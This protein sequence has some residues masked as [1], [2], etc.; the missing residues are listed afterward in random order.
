MFIFRSVFERLPNDI[1]YEVFDYLQIIHIY[2]A[3]LDLNDRFQNLLIHSNLPMKVNISTMSKSTFKRYHV[4]VIIP[5]RYRIAYLRLFN[6]FTVEMIFYPP[7]IIEEF[8]QL[9]KLVLEQI[10]AKYIRNIL[11]HAGALEKLHS[12]VISLIEP[13]EDLRRLWTPIFLLR[14]LKYC[15]VTYDPMNQQIS[16]FYL[17]QHNESS[18]EHLVLNTSITFNSLDKFLSRFPKLRR[19]AINNIIENWPLPIDF[20]FTSLNYLKYIS[21][22]LDGIPFDLLESF[23][24][25]F[26]HRVEV[27]SL[28]VLDSQDYL[29]AHRWEKL[30][31]SSM[32]ELRHF[33]FHHHGGVENDSQLY[34]HLIDQFNSSFWTQRG[35]YFTHQ[36]P[37]TTDF[38][39]GL[40]Y[41]TN[42]YP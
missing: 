17:S 15:K 6:P 7:R 39:H 8:I 35:W 22:K 40:F 34:H 3:F 20:P 30:I 25:Q 32:P 14:K 42:P 18:I 33:D 26:F 11:L 5:N 13:L 12:L 41:S 21:L 29:N 37:S 23:I 4:N 2:D 27:F 10:Y 31:L 16:S 36:H 1:L 38:S 24:R 28:T 9:E 19:L